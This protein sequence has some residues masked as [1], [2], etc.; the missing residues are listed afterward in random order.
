[1][2]SDYVLFLVL[3][4]ILKATG[5]RLI[6]FFP[7]WPGEWSRVDNIGQLVNQSD[8]LTEISLSLSDGLPWNFVHTA[9]VP[10]R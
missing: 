6:I 3:L 1:M 4:E 10:R 8:T 5:S 2:A 7:A 9:M